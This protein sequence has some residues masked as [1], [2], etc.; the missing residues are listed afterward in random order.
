M[1]L[2]AR[3]IVRDGSQAFVGSQSLRAIELDARRE[4]GIVFRDPQAVATL[5]KAFEADWT[6]TNQPFAREDEPAVVPA[7]KVAKRVA[8]AVT[9]ELPPVQPVLELTVREL[10]GSPPEVNLDNREVEQTVKHAVHEAVRQVVRD[11]VEE[12]VE[13]LS[14]GSKP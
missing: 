14:P 4:V 11:F 6:A 13:T 1:R 5:V 8:N 3:V 2:H 12:A 9:A 10:G 7:A